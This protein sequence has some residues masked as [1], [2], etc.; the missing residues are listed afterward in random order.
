MMCEKIVHFNIIINEKTQYFRPK[1]FLRIHKQNINLS[2]TCHESSVKLGK[3]N[4]HVKGHI[5]DKL[6]GE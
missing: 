3:I 1:I 5:A 2:R 6:Y 4:S